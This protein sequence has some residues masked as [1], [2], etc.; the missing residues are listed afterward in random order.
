MNETTDIILSLGSILLLGMA[1]DFIG[2]RTF[3]PRITILL[4][5]G[6]LIGQEVFDLIPAS[7]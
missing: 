2:K 1:A 4:I 5:L 7:L 3:L 6:I